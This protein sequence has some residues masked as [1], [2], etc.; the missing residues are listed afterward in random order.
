MKYF[1]LW[2]LKQANSNSLTWSIK[3]HSLLIIPLKK[4]ILI[5]CAHLNR[6]NR[7]CCK[8]LFILPLPKLFKKAPKV[9]LGRLHESD[10]VR[11]GPYLQSCQWGFNMGKLKL[12]QISY[13]VVH[14]E[15]RSLHTLYYITFP[16]IMPAG[17]L[18]AYCKCSCLMQDFS[19]ISM[20]LT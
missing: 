4:N 3:D 20:M 10:P 13:R 5:H 17:Y 8:V 18:Q 15:N 16:D 6:N 2:T 19:C 11:W 7:P 14:C 12:S 1:I 9:E